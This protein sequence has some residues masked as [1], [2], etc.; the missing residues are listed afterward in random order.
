M[1]AGVGIQRSNRSRLDRA[2]DPDAIL[3][4]RNLLLASR[5]AAD[6]DE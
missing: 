4:E 3:V 5:V 1:S 2:S 6:Y